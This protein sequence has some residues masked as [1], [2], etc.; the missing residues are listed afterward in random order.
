MFRAFNDVLFDDRSD[1]LVAT[2]RSKVAAW[3]ETDF[4]TY[5]PNAPELTEIPWDD[6]LQKL[7]NDDEWG[8]HLCLAA[9]S[10]LYSS[11]IY[12]VCS[13]DIHNAIL[14]PVHGNSTNDVYLFFTYEYHYDSMTLS[15]D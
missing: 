4:L 3:L 13:K 6:Y 14:T 1:E 11:T 2:L 7:R 8:D 12:I 15:P 5:N 10:A 9:L